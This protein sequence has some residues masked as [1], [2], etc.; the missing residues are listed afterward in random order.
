LISNFQVPAGACDAHV[1]FY[2]PLSRYPVAPHAVYSVPDA[3]PEQF[4]AL[5]D[6]VGLSRAVVVHAVASGRDNRRTLDALREYPERFR[7]VL[8]PPVERASDAMLI[9]WDRLGVSGVRFS[10]TGSAQPDMKIDDELVRRIGE[11][12]WHAQVHI[13]DDQVVELADRLAR[14]PGRVVIDHMAR[15]PASSGV[16]S[17]A[18]ACLLRLLDRGNVWVKLSAP[19]RLSAESGPPYDDVGAMARALVRHAPDRVVWGSDWPHVNFKGTVPGYGE[20]LGLLE[21]WA[22]DPELRRLILVDNAC[23]LYR[24]P[25]TA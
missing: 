5:Q 10:Y 24:F 2:G 3:T 14:L 6:S 22:P 20:L 19:M 17:Q 18:F 23:E 4:V 16:D 21:A 13:E 15:I 7:G 1:H 8:T 9:E 12:G 11:F 25:K